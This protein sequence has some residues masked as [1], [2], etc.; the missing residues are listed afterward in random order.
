MPALALLG[1]SL[2]LLLMRV[3]LPHGQSPAGRAVAEVRLGFRERM[4]LQRTNLYAFGLILLL[5]AVSGAV[6]YLFELIAIAFAYG[7][8]SIPVRYRFTSDG[9]GLNNVVFRRWSE[10]RGFVPGARS[11]RLQ[12]AEGMRDF[13]VRLLAGHQAP[14]LDV[15]R[16]HV[17]QDLQRGDRREVVR[18]RTK[19]KRRG[20]AAE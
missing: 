2:L 6:P 10:F 5:L 3:W 20:V 13:H 4:L 17:R 12:G 9:V 7:I 18:G 8:L 11:I 19:P 15:V 1:A 14:A 16:R